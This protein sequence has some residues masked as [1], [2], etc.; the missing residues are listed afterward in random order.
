MLLL[1]S[2]GSLAIL[3]AHT[4]LAQAK[5]WAKLRLGTD[6]TAPPAEFLLPD[7]TMVGFD[8]DLAADVCARMK[9]ECEWV[10]QDFDGFIPALNEG[11]FDVFFNSLLITE[12]RKQVIDFAAPF[13]IVRQGFLAQSQGPLEQVPASDAVI[14]LP[15]PSAAQCSLGDLTNALRGK[16]L[17]TDAGTPRVDVA[18]QCLPETELHLYPNWPKALDDLLTGRVDAVMAPRSF[19]NDSLNG[20]NG[21]KLKHIGPWYNGGLLGVNSSVALRKTDPD[22]KAMLD[23]AIKSALADGTV[24]KLS[25][26]WYK[27]DITPPT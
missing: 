8:I 2:I 27:V 12:K 10:R 11:K 6:P 24:R 4:G 22:L 14:A 25:L 21:A 23:T 19:I 13:S 5:D 1:L 16:S 17:G 3:I 20:P 9:V 15:D 7:G 26:K 18:K